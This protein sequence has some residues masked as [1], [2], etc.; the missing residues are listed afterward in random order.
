[1]IPDDPEPE[2]VA[3]TE[4]AADAGPE[5]AVSSAR[6]MGYAGLVPFALPVLGIVL[7]HR[8]AWF[9]HWLVAYG[10]VILSFVGALQ[11]GL[12]LDER[13]ERRGERVLVSVLPALAGWLALLLPQGA[14]IAL[15]IAGFLGIYAYERVT[16]WPGGYPVWFR[17]LRTQLTMG[18]CLLLG[19]GLIAA[20]LLP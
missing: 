12:A 6:W 18:A 2:R 15:L 14:G 8:D 1:V 11:W 13:R 17:R 7:G 4:R 16:V 9:L 20:L 19:A 5:V 10:A 3:A